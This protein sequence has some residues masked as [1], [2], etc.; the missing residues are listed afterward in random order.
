MSGLKRFRE[1]GEKVHAKTKRN[2]VLLINKA[3]KI[4]LNFG[5]LDSKVGM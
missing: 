3:S 5:F 1:F 4:G 2:Q